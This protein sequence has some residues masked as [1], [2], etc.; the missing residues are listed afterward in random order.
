MLNETKT[1]KIWLCLERL[2][3]RNTVYHPLPEPRP[4]G[5]KAKG[6]HNGPAG[7]RQ[8]AD[9]CRLLHWELGLGA[10]RLCCMGM[11]A[12]A[13]VVTLLFSASSPS[14]ILVVIVLRGS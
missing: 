7:V 14:K 13:R 10:G 8:A 11:V 5:F 2:Y 3:P 12:P 4:T 6:T 1:S 9:A